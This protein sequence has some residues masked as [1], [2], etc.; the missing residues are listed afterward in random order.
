MS[1]TSL[2]TFGLFLGLAAI[3]GAAPFL[4]TLG[5]GAKDPGLKV[6]QSLP[7]LAGIG[8]LNGP[9]P[10]ADELKGKV[11]VINCWATWCPKCHTGMP[12]LVKLH[13]KYGEKGVVFVGLTGEEEDALEDIN[14]FLEEYGV[15]WPNAYGAIDSSLALKAQYIPRYWVFDRS[16]KVI[17]NVASRGDMGEAIEEAL[18]DNG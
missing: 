7:K 1:K 9:L 11:V 2:Q 18:A 12:D 17:W 4:W 15:Q 8:T 13:E 5:G 14:D 10:S 16:G 6:G 3:V